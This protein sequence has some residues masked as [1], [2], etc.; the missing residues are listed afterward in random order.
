M[1]AKVRDGAPRPVKVG[2]AR[3]AARRVVPHAKREHLL[4]HADVL[5]LVAALPARLR[6]DLV[7][8][9][10]PYGGG[11]VMTAREVAG[12]RRGRRGAGGGRVAYD[13]A[14]GGVDALLAMLV[15]RLAALR[16]RMAP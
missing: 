2:A 7:Y 5:E 1:T 10:P 11:G 8:L 12:Q 3:E 14:T 9:D 4:F 6:F 16:E 15:P 13:D